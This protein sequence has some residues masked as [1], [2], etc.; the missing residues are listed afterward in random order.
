MH[1]K[2][3]EESKIDKF[4]N[5]NDVPIDTV[6][7]DVFS[8]LMSVIEKWLHSY[9][10]SQQTQQTKTQQIQQEQQTQ[11]VQRKTNRGNCDFNSLVES[12]L[13]D[14]GKKR[15]KDKSTEKIKGK[16]KVHYEGNASHYDEFYYP[17]RKRILYDFND[18]GIDYPD[19]YRK[20]FDKDST[21]ASTSTS[22]STSSSS[23]TSTSDSDS[24]AVYLRT[25]DGREFLNNQ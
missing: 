14:N 7:D 9:D 8:Y 22:T 18:E 16:P 19:E 20:R 11:Q 17:N 15:S 2:I 3:N 12:C 13:A 10:Q 4:I 1:L 5:T 21:S 23:I 24:D 25:T 6:K